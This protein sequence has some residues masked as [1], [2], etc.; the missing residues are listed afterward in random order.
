[1]PLQLAWGS[2]K[3]LF[4]VPSS[5][6]GH[7]RYLI[8]TYVASISERIER[9]YTTVEE[10]AVGLVAHITQFEHSSVD[11][12]LTRQVL[13]HLVRQVETDLLRGDDI[14]TFAASLPDR[15]QASSVFIKDYYEAVTAL[16]LGTRRRESNL[17]RDARD[18]KAKI[19]AILGGQGML[20]NYF[21]EL[22]D[23]YSTYRHLVSGLIVQMAEHLDLLA[24][25]P[26]TEKLFP[27]GLRA[28]TWLHNTEEKPDTAYLL[29]APVSFP[30]IGLIQLAH[31]TVTCQLL[32]MNP[33]ELRDSFEGIAGHSQG[34]ITAIV[35][36]QSDSWESFFR[37]AKAALTFL[38]WIGVR[39]QLVFP[40]R[41]HKPSMINMSLDEGVPTPMLSVR[42][43][44]QDVLQV[45]ID[46]ANHH[47]PPDKRLRIGL[48]NGANN[49]VVCGPPTSLCGLIT[50]LR[51]TRAKSD[52]DQ[53][54]IPFRERKFTFVC[55]FLPVTAPFHSPYLAPAYELIIED[56]RGLSF[57]RHDL[58]VPVYSTE[59]GRDLRDWDETNLG[60]ELARLITMKS[61]H[62]KSATVFKNA[63]HV[64]DFG[65]GGAFG[66]GLLTQT[67]KYGRGVRI[68]SATSLGGSG[69]STQIGGKEELLSRSAE[70]PVMYASHWLS[71]Y[72]PR[73]IQGKAGLSYL[74]T[75]FSRLLG[76]P[77]LM[78][79]GMTPCTTHWDFVVATM[80][81]GYHIELAG[82]GY[83]NP[84][85]FAM[86]IQKVARNIAPGR[87]I[88]LN[89]IYVNPAAI[90]WQIPLIRQL[91]AEGV[92]IDGL[93]IG[94]GVPSIEVA[95]EYIQTLGL[96]H[97]GFKPGSIESIHRVIEIARENSDFPVVLQWTG[98]RGGGHHSFEDFHQP[99][100]HT[101]GKIRDCSNIIL[102]GGSGFGGAEDTLPYLTGT[103]SSAFDLAP[104][105][106]DGILFGSR[107]MTAKEAH[108]SYKAKQLIVNAKGVEDSDWD[109]TYRKP[110][111]GVITVLSEMREPIHMLATRGV[112]FWAEMDEMIFSISPSKRVAVLQSKRQ[113]IIQKLNNDFQKVWFG[114]TRR[115]RPV[116]IDEMT[117]SE[118][119]D[120]LVELLYVDFQSRWIDTSYQGLLAAFIQRTEERF[121]T[122][123]TETL[124][125][126]PADLMDPRR[127]IA[128]TL[129]IYP[130]CS[131]QLVNAEDAK[132]FLAL[133]KTRGQKPVPFVP[134]LDANFEYWFKKDSLWQ[135][136]DI[137]A[138][139]DQDADRTC[140]LQGPVAVKYS[141]TADEPVKAILDGICNTHLQLLAGKAVVWT[142]STPVDNNAGLTETGTGHKDRSSSQAI[143]IHRISRSTNTALPLP[144]SWLVMLG[145]DKDAWRR[146]FFSAKTVT[147]GLRTVE[148]P[149]KTLFAPAWNIE[150]AIEHPDEPA[151]TIVKLREN[152]DGEST[153]DTVQLKS[154]TEGEIELTI[155]HHL[156]V[157]HEPVTLNLRFAYHPEARYAPIQE[158]MDQKI[159]N[160]KNFYW[161]L[162]FGRERRPFPDLTLG[163]E[164]DGGSLTVTKEEVAE[165]V[166]VVAS[167]DQA[168]VDEVEPSAVVPMDFVIKAAWKAMVMPLFGFEDN[169][170]DLVHLSNGFR[171]LPIIQPLRVGDVLRSTSCVNAVHKTGSGKTVE[172]FVT[173]FRDG[174]PIMN[175]K[176]CF[177]YRG[178]P[179]EDDETFECQP[180]KAVL[181]R[182]GSMQDVALLHSKSWFHLSKPVIDLVDRTLLFRYH[183]ETRQTSKARSR[184]SIIQGK[185]FL[186]QSTGEEN[187]Q[188]G[189]IMLEDHSGSQAASNPV[190]DYLERH[191]F[192][193]EEAQM[194]ESAIPLNT[195]TK[196]L[197]FH[198]PASNEMYSMVSGDFN[199]IHTSR[200]FSALAGL[201]GM[202]THG[203]Y[204]SSKVRGLVQT[205]V[206]EDDGKLFRSFD[207]SF[208]DMVLPK[209]R[210]QV[211]CFHAGMISGRK[212]VKIE[213]ST[214]G[215]RKVLTATAEIEQPTSAYVFA[216][217]GS[218]VQGMG[219]EL[220]SQNPVAREI[221]DRADMFLREHYGTYKTHLSN[222]NERFIEST[223]F[224]ILNI[225]RN[226]PKTLE[227]HFG[228]S[229]GRNI[230]HNYMR[231]T[232]EKPGIGG[233]RTAHKVLEDID[234]STTSYA[235]YFPQGLLYSTEFAQPALVLNAQATYA[236]MRQKGII[237]N[238][239]IYAGHSLGEYAALSALANVISLEN[240]VHLVFYRG[241]TMQRCV[242]RDEMRRSKYSMC[243][244]NPR[245]VIEGFD[246]AVLRQAVQAIQQETGWL[247]EI[248]NLN[249][250]DMQYV[251]AGDLRALDTL[252]SI[253]KHLGAQKTGDTVVASAIGPLIRKYADK[254]RS[255]PQPVDLERTKAA[256]P[257]QGIDVPFHSTFLRSGIGSF[258]TAIKDIIK[259]KDIDPRR[260][261][262]KYIPNLTGKPFEITKEYFQQVAQLTESPDLR[263]TLQEWDT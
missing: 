71:E 67:M 224:S 203:M 145:G 61:L 19:F 230:R 1:M 252:I 216:G 150:V 127:L 251:C 248:V 13:S 200:A 33:G 155:M 102:V 94:A 34:I 3:H 261:V 204:L 39:S 209:D 241:L 57:A 88:T 123:S 167:P 133:C 114:K 52:L 186:Q 141:K 4:L 48:F 2:L 6:H 28:L 250:K 105:P 110:S 106:F 95:T 115:G 158:I 237:D 193:L 253:T 99:I 146:T 120:R 215:G 121:S 77:P 176:S 143:E 178:R 20:E 157:L 134:A 14:H 80:N 117:Y 166:R 32:G 206:A 27:K 92:A 218:Q 197:T 59:D 30:L 256:I 126:N 240:L 50:Q 162:W 170:L 168:S 111:G 196:D 242:E 25:L 259:E 124:T 136:E 175:V 85:D 234:E 149:L 83:F 180:E 229:R 201:P 161:K 187:L 236:V 214:I 189:E 82:G 225:V 160:V 90:A 164:F 153:V 53:A 184:S 208:D 258:R 125:S 183:S 113:E 249:I 10:L 70:H 244:I 213:A 130:R 44:P 60:P 54:R 96:R 47:L 66:A 138:V 37:S 75:K 74:E 55:E 103:W 81:A 142:D 173:I 112:R 217:Q 68:I 5:I 86:A 232:V 29:A 174:E 144:K 255:K 263:R 79:A 8:D 9:T 172:V 45:Q 93:T 185:V 128:E 235:F 211:N 205:L 100:V 137:D 148:N 118:V 122:E 152:V 78:V 221:W 223:G 72:G 31:Y 24:R 212:I 165:F 192:P 58:K 131:Q 73:V 107:M 87:G 62:W 177:H 207:C 40:Q 194:F 210:I 231:L 7:A 199:P 89:L 239:C 233:S 247:L 228:G 132:F 129:R 222:R 159:E 227:I 51:K 171:K 41:V 23:I 147:Q 195:G 56:V 63:S 91:K 262:Q 15:Q 26:K 245:K 22:E 151:K 140:I 163:G 220:Y 97:I 16:K 17:L 64:L 179:E 109:L 46:R 238:N 243:A 98:G 104:M 219:M 12:T 119:L 188:V 154:L 42:H 169:L 254:A 135:S 84:R 156:N 11:F 35:I 116:D 108:T 226:N 182:L 101:Y 18:G 76:L 190:T 198:A 49:F 181:L 43:L 246:E 139:V 191:G 36:S 257:L 21:E 65:P 38:F 69:A 260:L 202:I